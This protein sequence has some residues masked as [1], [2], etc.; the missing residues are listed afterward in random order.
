[1][2]TKFGT[3]VKRSKAKRGLE[4]RICCPFCTSKGQSRDTGY[5]LWINP[6][7][8]VYRCWRCETRGSISALLG[9]PFKPIGLDGIGPAA[10]GSTPVC[11]NLPGDIIRLDHLPDDHVATRY[12]RNRGFNPGAIGRYFGVS[13]CQYGRAFGGKSFKFDTTNTIVFPLWMNGVLAGWQCRLMYNPDSLDNETC[14]AFG[15]LWDDEKKKFL[16]PPKYFTSPGLT[17]GMVLFNYDVARQA[18]IVVVTEGPT[19][20]LAAGPCA[21]GT[22]GKGVTDTQMALLASGWKIVV[23]L[24]D[25]DA[26]AE[27]TALHMD[28]S[29]R[30]SKAVLVSLQG[31]DDPGSAPTLEIWRQ[32]NA[33]LSA[34]GVDLGAI[35]MGPHWCSEI[36]RK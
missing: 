25:P 27:A 14:E 13:Y 33:A 24:L 17:K 35:N 29:R 19:D 31:Y 4:L 30:T 5:K 32:I 28:L 9:T 1:L 15:F 22:L 12:M 2:R 11:D 3:T 18:D 16:R 23:V 6:G 36:L 26:A 10:I 7:M 20:V 21:V 8:G 34:S